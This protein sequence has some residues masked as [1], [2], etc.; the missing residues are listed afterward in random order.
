MKNQ[1]VYRVILEDSRQME[2]L[3]AEV[4]RLR[5]ELEKQERRMR[6]AEW[7]MSC[8]YQINIQLTDWL[9]QEKITFPRRL[10]MAPPKYP[11][12]GD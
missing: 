4:S 6:D 12:E 11:S 7:R 9:R 8:E 5:A 2:R 3:K 1:K 10:L